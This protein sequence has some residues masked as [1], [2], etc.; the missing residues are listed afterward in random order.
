MDDFSSACHSTTAEMPSW[1]T[2]RVVSHGASATQLYIRFKALCKLFRVKH[3]KLGR[4]ASDS[5]ESGLEGVLLG[6]LGR[7]STRYAA[8]NM[9][10]LEPSVALGRLLLLV[11]E[12]LVRSDDRGKL[13]GE[14][15]GRRLLLDLRCLHGEP[16]LVAVVVERFLPVRMRGVEA[17][18]FHLLGEIPANLRTERCDVDGGTRRR[19]QLGLGD[20]PIDLASEFRAVGILERAG[21][22]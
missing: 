1:P 14:R 21:R 4:L 18:Q 7:H 15:S 10:G 9:S 16:D 8:R 17:Q 19:G 3:Q 12:G 11:G 13:S 22:L 20:A 2:S 6:R 5:V